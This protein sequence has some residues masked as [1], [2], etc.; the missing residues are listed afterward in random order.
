MREYRGI[1]T[2]RYTYVRDLENPWMLYDND[3]DPL[4]NCNLIAEKGFSSVP[5]ELE[6][7][8]DRWIDKTAD[9]LKDTQYYIDRIDLETGLALKPEEFTR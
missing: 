5:P 4:Q 7:E 9:P 3:A 2:E 1:R 6:T 8:L